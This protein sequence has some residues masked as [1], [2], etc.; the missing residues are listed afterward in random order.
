MRDLY[1]GKA[2]GAEQDAC[3]HG[4]ALQTYCDAGSKFGVALNS[5]LMEK[6]EAG[7][8][9]SVSGI[10]ALREATDEPSLARGI[11]PSLRERD[12]VQPQLEVTGTMSLTL[13][14]YAT[15]SDVWNLRMGGFMSFL[16]FNDYWY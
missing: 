2:S 10:N 9:T 3:I 6:S 15:L 14:L 5:D 11:A 1:S 12:C 7:W 16:K 4:Q 8:V 13:D